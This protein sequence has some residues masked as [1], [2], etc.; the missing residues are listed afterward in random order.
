MRVLSPLRPSSRDTKQQVSPKPRIRV[1]LSPAMAV[2]VLALFLALGTPVV[3]SHG[4][5]AQL[6][7][8]CVNNA[9]G[10]VTVIADTTGYRNPN[11]RCQ[12]PS[13]QHDLDW[14]QT[15]PAGPA[16][17][18]GAIGA[19]GQQGPA[20]VSAV[21]AWSQAPFKGPTGLKVKPG[22]LANV[23]NSVSVAGGGT[24]IVEAEVRFES[25]SAPYIHL[26]CFMRFGRQLDRDPMGTVDS[27]SVRNHNPDGEIKEGH[28]HLRRVLQL[29]DYRGMPARIWV[30]CRFYD[31]PETPAKRVVFLRA[32]LSALKLGTGAR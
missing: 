21:S 30:G 25:S 2:A 31:V 32:R 4:G 10:E 8:A 3:W 19:P 29:P 26:N 16:G 1:R 24:Y 17:P 5:N 27:T 18:Q 15:G 20:G 6:V 28:V 14:A 23:L 7:H 12:R 13:E 11:A 22:G 9:T